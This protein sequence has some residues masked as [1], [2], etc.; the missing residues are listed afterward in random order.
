MLFFSRKK[1]IALALIDVRALINNI[2]NDKLFYRYRQD[3]INFDMLEKRLHII[4]DKLET[5][6]TTLTR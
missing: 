4:Q 3:L 2:E 5:I 1:K 6:F